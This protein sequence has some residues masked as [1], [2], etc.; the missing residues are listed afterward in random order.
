MWNRARRMGISRNAAKNAT[1]E[2]A[3]NAYLIVKSPTPLLAAEEQQATE[4][5][6]GE[7]IG[8]RLGTGEA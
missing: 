7:R 2:E 3:T 8:A 1:R 6:R 5:Q 4:T